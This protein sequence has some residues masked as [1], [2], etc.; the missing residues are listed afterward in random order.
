M[1]NS[2]FS[3]GMTIALT[4]GYKLGIVVQKLI[5]RHPQML[6]LGIHD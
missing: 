5:Y 6:L 2:R 1:E 4:D 3:I